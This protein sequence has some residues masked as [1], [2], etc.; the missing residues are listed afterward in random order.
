MFK[1]INKPNIS[2]ISKN[3]SSYK[4]GKSVI[5]YNSWSIHKSRG[6]VTVNYFC[7]VCVYYLFAITSATPLRPPKYWRPASLFAGVYPALSPAKRRRRTSVR[8]SNGLRPN[9]TDQWVCDLT[10]HVDTTRLTET[11]YVD[12]CRYCS[13]SDR[14]WTANSRQWYRYVC[15]SARLLLYS[16]FYLQEGESCHVWWRN[17]LYKNFKNFHS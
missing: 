15:T 14:V 7:S 8:P 4:T 3:A 5:C 9:L 10:Q 13:L 2:L 16:V 11:N 12:L 6:N 1:R 17:Q